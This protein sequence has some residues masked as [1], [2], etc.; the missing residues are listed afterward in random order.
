MKPVSELLKRHDSSA[1][2]T[3]PGTTVFD[4]SLIHI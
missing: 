1:W 2:R 3:S 4:L